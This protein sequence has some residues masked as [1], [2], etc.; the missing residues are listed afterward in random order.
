MSKTIVPVAEFDGHICN[1][2]P[3]RCTVCRARAEFYRV[4]NEKWA[5]LKA[6]W[7]VVRQRMNRPYQPDVMVVAAIMTDSEEDKAI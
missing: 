5:R 1:L 6:K 4:S 3:E 2:G 7:E